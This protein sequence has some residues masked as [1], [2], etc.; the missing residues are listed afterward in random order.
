MGKDT[1]QS[2]VSKSNSPLEVDYWKQVNWDNEL[3]MLK[4]PG[5]NVSIPWR[6]NAP[7]KT[8]GLSFIIRRNKTQKSCVHS[9]AN[10]FM[11]A[12]NRPLDEPQI[13][14]F[15]KLVSFGKEVTVSI[16]PKVRLAEAEIRDVS[17]EERKCPFSDEVSL[18]GMD[19]YVKYSRKHCY[20]EC[21]SKQ[22]YKTCNCSILDAPAT[23]DAD[24][25]SKR[26]NIFDQ[27]GL[28]GGAVS[29]VT[30]L[31]LLD[32]IDFAFTTIEVGCTA[33]I[34][35]VS[36]KIA[37]RGG[38]R[39]W[40]RIK[41]YFFPLQ[42]RVIRHPPIFPRDIPLLKVRSHFRPVLEE[43]IDMVNILQQCEDFR[44]RNE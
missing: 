42:V 29:M 7:G 22:I 43:R 17:V 20:S 18:A 15:G 33:L 30:G 21:I 38:C 44:R 6:Q 26:Y 1:L 23:A 37:H 34:A 40:R 27:I 10:G 3:D 9:D 39:C 4:T 41:G 12:V 31:T 25:R 35:F 19:F 36:K 2:V 16:L 24:R 5:L 32:V 11:V 28:S 14:R 8:S 13:R